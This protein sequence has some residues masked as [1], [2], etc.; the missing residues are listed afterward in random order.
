MKKKMTADELMERLEAMSKETSG[1]GCLTL[2][3]FLTMPI[4]WV[5]L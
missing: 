5:I 1:V 4:M 3:V 2:I